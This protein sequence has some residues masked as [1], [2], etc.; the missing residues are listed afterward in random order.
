MNDSHEEWR[1]CSSLYW[2]DLV[3]GLLEGWWLFDD[4]RDHALADEGFWEKSLRDAGFGEVKWT[5]GDTLESQTMR[6]ICA[7]P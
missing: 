5:D 6:L 1:G 3:Y 7:F 4:G 2:F